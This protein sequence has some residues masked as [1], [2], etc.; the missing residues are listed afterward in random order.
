MTEGPP[1]NGAPDQFKIT[2]FR[3]TN[4]AEVAHLK[5]NFVK[6]ASM[7]HRHGSRVFPHPWKWASQPASVL[8]KVRHVGLGYTRPAADQ[9]NARMPV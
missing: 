1:K 5:H 8:T 6:L 4:R 7:P 9:L 2:T 3:L